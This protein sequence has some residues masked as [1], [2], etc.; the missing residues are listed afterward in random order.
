MNK[1]EKLAQGQLDNEFQ[2]AVE[3]ELAN[4]NILEK[5][6]KFERNEVAANLIVKNVPTIG[7]N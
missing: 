5:T 4:K 6:F 1:N 3:A 7:A 2:I